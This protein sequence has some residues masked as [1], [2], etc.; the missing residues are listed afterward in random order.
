MNLESFQNNFRLMRAENSWGR[1]VIALCMVAI[2]LLAAV[3]LFRKPVVTLIPPGLTEQSE[4]HHNKAQAGIHSAWS[5]F[6]A[7]TLG[8]VTPASASFIRTTIEP[9]LAPGIRE[10][11]LKL[12]EQQIDLIKR[13]QVSY[14]FEPRE[15]Q[16][17]DKTGTSY[18]IGRHFTHSGIGNPDRVNRTYEFRWAFEN[19]MPVLVHL[20]TYEGAPRVKQQE[21]K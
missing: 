17:D 9:L 5:L 11:T 21:K 12:L 8:N 13:E 7:K 3:A 14:S 6:M 2:I 19:Y 10:Q 18:V 20:D 4:L 15:V 1:V 16:H